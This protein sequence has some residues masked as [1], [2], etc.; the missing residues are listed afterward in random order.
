LTTLKE[1]LK[2]D[3]DPAK[4]RTIK[5]TTARIGPVVLD[6]VINKVVRRQ[7][8]HRTADKSR[9]VV[10]LDGKEI[11]G[12]RNG[13]RVFLFCALD[14]AAEP[15]SHR[16]RSARK[17]M[18]FRSSCS[19]SNTTSAPV[20]AGSLHK[21]GPHAPQHNRGQNS[22]GRTTIWAITYQPVRTWIG[23][24]RETN[25]PTP[26]RPTQS[27]D[28]SKTQEHMSGITGLSQAEATPEQL[29]A[30]VMVTLRNV[31]ISLHTSTV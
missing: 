30:R 14:H 31:A 20:M 19:R 16:N 26:L 27:V 1:A 9:T 4:E 23:P 29:A 17:R 25:R 2:K 10:A 15:S 3:P 12:T 21:P 24:P 5:R 6:V 8:R 7:T 22:H 28:K 11:R 13:V 18:R